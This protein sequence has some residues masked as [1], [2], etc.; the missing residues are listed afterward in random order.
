MK[1]AH[2][3]FHLVEIFLPL[4]DK[5]IRIWNTSTGD[6][7]LGPLEGHTYRVY[8][9]TFMPEG[10]ILISVSGHRSIRF[11]DLL[12]RQPIR[13]E[14][15]TGSEVYSLA[16]S[17]D[18][19]TIAA[20]CYDCTIK[21]YSTATRALLRQC[22][23]HSGNVLTIV[24]SS[25]GRCL[26]SVSADRTARIWDASTGHAMGGP[27]RGHTSYI[28]S[29]AFSPNGQ[30]IASGSE[31]RTILIWDVETRETVEL[32]LICLRN[33]NKRNVLL[34]SSSLLVS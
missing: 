34:L 19:M 13:Q 5:T 32:R 31:D 20:A 16:V 9:V 10:H 1:S 21:I 12:T 3:P 4:N 14:I 26:A 27:L 7:V 25:N 11:W 24:F 28:H 18:G 22:K 23:G 6:A 2:H 8:S 33:S 15:E 29:I 17:L 30:Y